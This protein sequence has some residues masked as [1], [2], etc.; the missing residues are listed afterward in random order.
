MI[1]NVQS[2]VQPRES[3]HELN[4]S[5]EIEVGIIVEK[6]GLE[7]IV[8][9][10][11]HASFITN[12]FVHPTNQRQELQEAMEAWEEEEM[13]TTMSGLIEL[14]RNQYLFHFKTEH[15]AIIENEIVGI[16]EREKVT[17]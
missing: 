5:D 4:M 16:F 3:M 1:V 17:C 15:D 7:E 10:L 9:V 2:V 6:E 12:M 8:K 11:E 14:L 13:D